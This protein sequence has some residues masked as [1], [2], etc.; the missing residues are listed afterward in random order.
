MNLKSKIFLPVSIVVAISYI[1]LGYFNISGSYNTQYENIKQKEIGVATREAH[2]VDEFLKIRKD[3]IVSMS[4]RVSSFDKEVELEQIREISNLSKDTGGFSSV[5]IGYEDNGLMTRWSGKDST[6]E[7]DNFDART[8]PWYKDAKA[9][10]KY[11]FTKPYID[12]STKQLAISIYSPIIDKSNNL[13]GVVSSDLLLKDIVDN[14]LNIDIGN[15]GIAYLIDEAGNTLVHKDEKLIGQKNIVFEKIEATKENFAEIDFEGSKKLVSIA[16]IPTSSWYLILEMDKKI[17]FAPIYSDLITF[18]IIS[19]LFLIVTI[20]GLIYLINNALAPLPTLQNGVISFF[21][22]LKGEKSDAPTIL[23]DTNDE[24]KNMANEINSGIIGIKETLNSDREFLEDVQDVMNKI[25]LGYFNQ[26]IKVSPKTETLVHLKDTI[27]SGL[28]N[29]ENNF[30]EINHTLDGYISMNYIKKLDV[31]GVDKDSTVEQLVCKIGV[32]RET[33]I[34]M[35]K[36]NKKNGTTLNSSASSLMKNVDVLN[37]ASNTAAAS[38]EE[39][40]AA[41]EE[42]MSTVSSNAQNVS[43]MTQ[44]AQGLRDSVK[45]GEALATKTNQ[46]MDEINK[47]VSSI[48]E[49]IEVIDQIAF[50]TNI[51]SLNAAVEAATAGEVGKGFAVV[52]QEVRNLASRSAE[53]AKQIK[54][55]VETATT[56]ANNGKD[57]ASNMIEDYRVLNENI[58]KTLDLIENVATASKEQEQGIVQITSAINNLDQQTQKNAQTAAHTHE[59]ARETL[60]ISATVLSNTNNKLFEE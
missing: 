26:S 50:Q 40:A 20:F 53:A 36:E 11:G 8:R 6:P 27:N 2:I 9:S 18:A 35:L 5:Y 59:I 1:I 32:L 17:A 49:A 14:I 58:T 42:I 54:E 47:E 37:I 25:E 39:T 56:K 16:K 10:L 15:D 3:L 13:I 60:D 29:L 48:T 52:A 28:K 55:L 21:S 46:S 38:L 44:N 22:Y 34:D 41:L 33:I 57:I 43:A 45:K 23:I 30:Q 24:F 7:K 12:N 31:C 51:L 4:K 19:I